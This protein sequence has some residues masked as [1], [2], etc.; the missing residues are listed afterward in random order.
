MEVGSSPTFATFAAPPIADLDCRFTRSLWDR[1]AAADAAVASYAPPEN[2]RS[3]AEGVA[4]RSEPGDAGAMTAEVQRI[5]AATHLARVS[6]PSLS[7]FEAVY[8]ALFDGEAD[9]SAWLRPN[10][11]GLFPPGDTVPDPS[12][13]IYAPPA[14]A[15]I[16]A[17]MHDLAA[18]CKRD[19]FT[20]VSQAAIAFA[21]FQTIHPLRGM[22]G[23]R[24]G[25][26]HGGHGRMGRVLVSARLRG[27]NTHG[28]APPVGVALVMGGQRHHGTLSAFQSG[29][30]ESWL[31]IFADAARISA[32]QPSA[33]LASVCAGTLGLRVFQ[34]DRHRSLAAQALADCLP[35]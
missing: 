35:L 8:A 20:P 11:I 16:E 21:Q 3:V 17:L 27:A 13:M 9:P 19:D 30:W 2:W 26:P 4:H 18:F 10:R 28:M 31:A 34:R 15:E 29:D 32:E 6:A 5:L 25:A 14:P 24:D 1:L 23:L 33:V 12:R 7:T 22:T